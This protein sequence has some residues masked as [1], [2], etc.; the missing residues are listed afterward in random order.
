MSHDRDH[1]HRVP[2]L[3]PPRE[4]PLGSTPCPDHKKPEHPTVEPKEPVD[5]RVHPRRPIHARLGARPA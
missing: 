5:P 2:G 3:L 4:P 1:E